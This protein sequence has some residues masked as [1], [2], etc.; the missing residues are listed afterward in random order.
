MVWTW[1]WLDMLIDYLSLYRARMG[2][3]ERIADSGP[4]AGLRVRQARTQ[5]WAVLT[6]ASSGSFGTLGKCCHQQHRSC[7]RRT[8][9]TAGALQ[10][11][12]RAF[13]RAV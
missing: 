10:L 2:F 3:E 4:I 7:K 5:K 9:A 13:D 1:L 8:L 11:N 6:I 12:R